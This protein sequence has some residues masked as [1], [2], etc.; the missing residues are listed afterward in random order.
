MHQDVVLLIIMEET[1]QRSHASGKSSRLQ[2]LF[3]MFEQHPKN[4]TLSCA[5]FH[6][7]LARLTSDPRLAIGQK[8]PVPHQRRSGLGSHL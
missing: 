7:R 6:I 4:R 1:A 5:I 8:R 2:D 3:M